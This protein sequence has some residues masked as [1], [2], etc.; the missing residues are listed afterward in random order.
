MSDT[1]STSTKEQ[2][3]MDRSQIVNLLKQHDV[4]PTRQRIEIAGYLFQRPQHLSAENILEG[5]NAEGNRVSRATVYNTMG[6]FTD[7]G[8]VRQV[9]IDRERV[10]YDTNRA[11]HYHVYDVDSGELRDVMRSEIEIASIP[12]LPEGA[13]IVDTNVIL[14]VSSK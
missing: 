3:P 9:L 14:R 1:I 6:L 2:Y 4:T 11:D 12:E 13:R 7:K 5:V 10:F 8:L